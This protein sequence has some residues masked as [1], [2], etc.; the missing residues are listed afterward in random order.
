MTPDEKLAAA[1]RALGGTKPAA[2]L[3]TLAALA[4]A[5]LA[6]NPKAR[7]WWVDALLVLAL[8]LVMGAVGAAVMGWNDEQHH[9][10]TK[11]GVGAA[12]LVLMAVASV[13]G[14]RPGPSRWR[15]VTLGGFAF[16]SVAT[17]AA[18]SG[19]DPG[20]PFS[21]GMWCAL[22]ECKLAL[23][24]VVVVVALSTRFA[25]RAEH[26]VVGALAG[27]SGGAMALHFHCPNGTVEHVAVFHFLPAIVLAVLALAVRSRLKSSSWAP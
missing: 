22:A 9:S 10:V 26:L 13:V 21:D 15:W 24:P 23:V 5:E 14:L 3:D 25:A 17:L 1:G 7:A 11:Y 6:A 18:L 19:F 16:L 8:N 4:K 20:G 12:W 27:A 2:Q